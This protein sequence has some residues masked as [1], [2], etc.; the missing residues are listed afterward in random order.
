MDNG[1]SLSPVRVIVLSRQAAFAS[2]RDQD[3]G[4]DGQF[5]H[6]TTAYEA[7][8]E[9][10]A[11][12]TAVL[13]IDLQA[14][15]SRHVRLL[16]IARKAGAE[17]LLAGPVPAGMNT[18]VLSGAKLMGADDL[19]SAVESILAEKAEA[20]ADKSEK[21][22]EELGNVQPDKTPAR[23]QTKTILTAAKLHRKP[24]QADDERGDQPSEDRLASPLLTAEEI[25]ALLG[26]QP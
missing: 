7:A 5:V 18:Q 24:A 2:L 11:N 23:P 9:I 8:A 4:A 1:G 13:V 25:S 14:F 6:V 17:M 16:E 20:V 15:A 3:G 19:S 21:P 26:D 12:P 10:L 22:P